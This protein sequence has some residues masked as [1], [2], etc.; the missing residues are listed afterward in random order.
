MT[1]VKG[2][3]C[4][5][6]PVSTFPRTA[7]T[8]A[9]ALNVSKISDEPTSPACRIT[10]EP[11][12]ACTAAFLSS[13]CVSEINPTIFLSLGNFLHC[14]ALS[15]QVYSTSKLNSERLDRRPQLVPAEL[16]EDPQ[17]ISAKSFPIIFT[18]P[19]RYPVHSPV[20]ARPE[21]PNADV[22]RL[23]GPLRRPCPERFRLR[24][25][26]LLSRRFQ[27]NG[28]RTYKFLIRGQQ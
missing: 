22:A 8:G 24:P 21:G 27:R 20:R 18:A 3:V 9:R 1:S 7:T 2:R 5:Q 13:P 10:S 15:R 11:R 14:E 26:R 12:S 17:P 19:S 4:P 6:A 23:R 25:R 28:N 16:I